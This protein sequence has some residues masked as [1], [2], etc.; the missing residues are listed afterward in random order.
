[1]QLETNINNG[2]AR[3]S[4]TQPTLAPTRDTYIGTICVITIKSILIN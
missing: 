2:Q 4:V 3:N 1:M